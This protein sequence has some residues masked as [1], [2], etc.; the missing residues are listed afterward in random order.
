MLDVSTKQEPGITPDQVVPGV[1]P[2]GETGPPVRT[3]SYDPGKLMSAGIDLMRFELG[4]TT[5]APGELTAALC[6]QEYA[7]ALERYPDWQKAKL[8]CLRAIVM[9]F[10]HQVTMSVD[11]GLRYDFGDRVRVWRAMLKEAERQAGGALPLPSG[12][13]GEPYFYAGM[14]ANPRKE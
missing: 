12:C 13:G 11:G 7:A 9:R 4:D 5:L 6:D 10:S 1:V 8:C 14:L 3:Y 2:P